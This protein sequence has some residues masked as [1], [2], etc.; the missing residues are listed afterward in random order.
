M[1]ASE[2]LAT[3]K[4]AYSFLS[5]FSPGS[6]AEEITF[7][8]VTGTKVTEM[9]PQNPLRQM[10]VRRTEHDP[11]PTCVAVQKLCEL[12]I[13]GISLLGSPGKSKPERQPILGP[14]TASE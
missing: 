3:K 4:A 11:A 8:H 5:Q 1:E 6:C 9:R 13:D 14:L 7:P 12:F 2:P 10:R